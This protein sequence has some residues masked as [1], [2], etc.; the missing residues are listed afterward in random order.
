MNDFTGVKRY[1]Y[2]IV[3]GKVVRVRDWVVGLYG[4]Y[5]K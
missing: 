5:G 4:V 1:T 2:S 3:D